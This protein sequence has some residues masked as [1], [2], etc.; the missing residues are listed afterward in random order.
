VSKLGQSV[1]TTDSHCV[2]QSSTVRH[3]TDQA[4]GCSGGQG[5]G[6][7]GDGGLQ[8]LGAE[9]AFARSAACLSGTAIARF[10]DLREVWTPVQQPG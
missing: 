5:A 3:A 6:R 2:I 8:R 10:D 1:W 7:T 4:D 9:A